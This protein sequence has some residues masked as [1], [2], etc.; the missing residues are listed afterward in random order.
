MTMIYRRSHDH[1]HSPVD[2]IQYQGL[3][4]KFNELCRICAGG[5]FV[6][7]CGKDCIWQ[8]R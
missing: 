4:S 3:L 8:K 7:G 1:G 5:G 6:M 2:V